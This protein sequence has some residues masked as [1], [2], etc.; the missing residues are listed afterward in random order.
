VKEE[1]KGANRHHRFAC[2]EAS[3]G[4]VLKGVLTQS[5]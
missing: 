2:V 4:V 1:D 3:M 5:I